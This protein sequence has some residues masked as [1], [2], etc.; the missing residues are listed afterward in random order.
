MK[1]TKPKPNRPDALD[2][3]A[4]QCPEP[5]AF[6]GVRFIRSE[7]ERRIR[8]IIRTVLKPSGKK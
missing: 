7:R 5:A 8:Q 3:N 4:A 6:D 1:K 2:S